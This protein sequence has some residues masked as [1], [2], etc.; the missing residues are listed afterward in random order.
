[1]KMDKN[2]VDVSVNN[3][4]AP[5]SKQWVAPVVEVHE[6][7]DLTMTGPTNS[8]DGAGSS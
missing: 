7:E 5:A 3:P 6:V 1:M 8:I 2:Q 4:S